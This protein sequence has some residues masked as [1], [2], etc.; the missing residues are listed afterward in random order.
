MRIFTIKQCLKCKY[1]AKASSINKIF[2]LHLSVRYRSAVCFTDYS[3][4]RG[5]VYSKV[6]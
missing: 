6:Y 2:I 4:V 3:A 1:I 5:R